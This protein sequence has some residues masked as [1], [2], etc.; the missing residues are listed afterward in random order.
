MAKASNVT[1]SLTLGPKRPRR[2]RPFLPEIKVPSNMAVLLRSL[3]HRGRTSGGAGPAF[4]SPC[5]CLGLLVVNPSLTTL[6]GYSCGWLFQVARAVLP[7]SS[8]LGRTLSR[9]FSRLPLHCVTH[10]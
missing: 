7:G 5:R 2:V 4:D 6:H 3:S 10:V 8:N 1:P 9:V